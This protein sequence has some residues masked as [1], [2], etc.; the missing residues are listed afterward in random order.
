MFICANIQ[1]SISILLSLSSIALHI[2]ILLSNQSGY[3]CCSFIWRA[4]VVFLFICGL[5]LIT[6]LVIICSRLVHSTIFL[7]LFKLFAASSIAILKGRT[8]PDKFSVKYSCWMTI[9]MFF[10]KLQIIFD[11]VIYE[12]CSQTVGRKKISL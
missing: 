4:L 6:F 5:L 1:I 8:I 7:S 2:D 10:F 12:F 3:I 11:I 9:S